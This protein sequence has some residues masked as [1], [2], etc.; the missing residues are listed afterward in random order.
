MEEP[1]FSMRNTYFRAPSNG[2]NGALL[3]LS[4]ETQNAQ[5]F[6]PKKKIVLNPLH[7]LRLRQSY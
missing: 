5:V 7:A 2:N 1:R 6:F 3:G 4:W